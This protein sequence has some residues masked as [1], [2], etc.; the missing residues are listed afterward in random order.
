MK[1]S[2]KRKITYDSCNKISDGATMNVLGTTGSISYSGTERMFRE[3]SPLHHKFFD[4]GCSHGCMIAMAMEF[5]A[6]SA[7]GIELTENMLSGY[8]LF[9]SVVQ[10]AGIDP[11][12]VNIRYGDISKLL[13]LGAATYIFSFWNSIPPQARMAIKMLVSKSP[14]ARVFACS[15]I[16]GEESIRRVLSIPDQQRGIIAINSKQQYWEGQ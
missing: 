1:S 3:V 7:A 15:N 16:P 13:G 4:L 10:G 5:G 6:N 8:P 12:A 9:E 2:K 14:T 11:L